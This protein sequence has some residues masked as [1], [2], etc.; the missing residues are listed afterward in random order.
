MT[1]V[2]R[3]IGHLEFGTPETPIIETVKRALSVFT[4][5]HTQYKPS[6]LMVN[7]L[8]IEHEA[9]LIAMG[10]EVRFTNAVLAAH[11]AWVGAPKSGQ[12]GA[13][14]RVIASKA[15][16]TSLTDAPPVVETVIALPVI[17]DV[18][19]IRGFIRL[20]TPALPAPSIAGLLLAVNPRGPEADEQDGGEE[21]D[22]PE[23]APMVL[24]REWVRAWQLVHMHTQADER[25]GVSQERADRNL[26]LLRAFMS[27]AVTFTAPLQPF[28][29]G[30]SAE[31]SQPD[32]LNGHEEAAIAV[33]L[34]ERMRR[35]R[36]RAMF[37]RQLADAQPHPAYDIPIA[38]RGEVRMM[39][40]P[41]LVITN[42]EAELIAALHEGDTLLVLPQSLQD[43]GDV[44]AMMRE[45]ADQKAQPAVL[46]IEARLEQ[47]AAERAAVAHDKVRDFLEALEYAVNHR[48]D[49]QAQLLPDGHRFM[50]HGK[51]GQIKVKH[52]SLKV[53][54]MLVA[55]QLHRAA[56]FRFVA[57]PHEVRAYLEKC[58][59]EFEAKKIVRISA[60]ELYPGEVKA[61]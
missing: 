13:A 21:E 18:Q 10:L 14:V 25:I 26:A 28:V 24:N 16:A 36:I 53:E 52:P 38:C 47:V 40:R 17:D 51:Q 8:N 45:L 37:E 59:R 20:S 27:D 15:I 32:G 55:V 50:R 33:K 5:K 19:I 7:P 6:I 31:P 49:E 35:D 39:Q 3:T 1:Q 2:T 11:H 48:E 44:R 43:A 60:G 56:G 58:E 9:E 22:T 30:E 46:S 34:P 41:A 29:R 12:S 61:A 42:E 57:R 4:A 23:L 54:P